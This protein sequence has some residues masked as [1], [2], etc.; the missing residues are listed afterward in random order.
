MNI[1]LSGSGGFIGKNLK[2]FL[3]NKSDVQNLI[4]PRSSE[5]DLKNEN[6]VKLFFQEHND[7]NFVI[8][9]A[10]IGGARGLEDSQTTI[11]DNLAMV[12]NILKY[13]NTDCRV[14][15][16]S[17]GAMYGKDRDLVKV[18]ESELGEYEPKDLYGKSKMLI[19]QKVKGM[20]DVL[21]L[22]IFACYGYG[23]KDSRFPSYAINQVL[24]GEEIVINQNVLF[25][26]L[27][28]EDMEKLVYTL[29]KTEQWKHNIVNL[30]PN[31]S[32]DLLK[33][34][35]LANS[36]SFKK[37]AISIKEPN[38]GKAY[39]GNNTLLKELVGEN[40]CFTSIWVGMNK[41]YNHIKDSQENYEHV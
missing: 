41:L 37:V 1:F 12:D 7:I 20:Q 17:S 8:H 13:K 15:L 9:C 35:N 23:E 32:V 16:F 31:D 5:L 22:N 3:S 40:F 30:T 19:A 18:S 2:E 25:D 33:L 38:L 34:A 24:K 14:I 29:M 28:V 26:Y 6:A 4:T 21:C 10:S 27:F 39:T 36:F 11:E